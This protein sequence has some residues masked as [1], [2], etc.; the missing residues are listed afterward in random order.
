MP[1]ALPYC[2][3]LFSA[4]DATSTGMR[5]TGTPAELAQLCLD[6]TAPAHFSG[7]IYTAGGSEAILVTACNPDPGG[8][9]LLTIQRAFGSSVARSW[10]AGACIK[11]DTRVDGAVC[12]DVGSGGGA[13]SAC[14][15]IYDQ[16]TVGKGLRINRDDPANPFLE[17]APTGVVASSNVGGATINACGQI[18]SYPPNWPASALPVFNPCCDP[19]GAG[20]GAVAAAEVSFSPS[21]A[22]ITA[23]NTQDAVDQLESHVNGLTFNSGVLALTAGHCIAIGGT[24]ANPVVGVTPSGIAPGVY[25]G[26]SVDLCG[27]ITSYTAPA[28]VNTVVAGNSPI[29]VSVAGLTYTVSIAQA[30]VGQ[31]GTVQLASTANIGISE[32][33]I[34][35]DDVVTWDF[36]SLWWLNRQPVLPTVSGV[37][38]VSVSLVGSNY[39]VA[40]RVADPLLI[41]APAAETLT[42]LVDIAYLRQWAA[43]RTPPIV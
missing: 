32:N 40:V 36:L 35:G 33:L 34:A 13:A 11:L 2:T 9:T 38:P 15:S 8:F 24:T 18:V 26:F 6:L 5:V 29:S 14:P 17:L 37:T 3:K 1:L 4:L 43:S 28:G 30:G 41:P 20:P 25:A 42:D 21:G 7:T 31:E 22:I 27:R 16:L 39:S 10:P 19:G 23:T 12:P